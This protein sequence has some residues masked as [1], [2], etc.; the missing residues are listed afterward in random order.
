MKETKGKGCLWLKSIE[1][2][3]KV[4]IYNG[5]SICFIST[6]SFFVLK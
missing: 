4:I 5:N 1:K 6:F 3:K 2:G